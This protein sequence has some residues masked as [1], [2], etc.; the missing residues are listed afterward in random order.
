M[1]DVLVVGS[2]VVDRFHEVDGEVS[3][4]RGGNG[5]ITA[6]WFDNLGYD[7]DL[8]SV[9][10]DDVSIP[11]SIDTSASV[12][13]DERNSVCD[14]FLNELDEPEGWEF[15]PSRSDLSPGIPNESYELSV[16]TGG[17]PGY[18]DLLPYISS[19]LNVFDPDGAIELYKDNTRFERAISQTEIL[20]T[21]S[22]EAERIEKMLGIEIQDLCETFGIEEIIVTDSDRVTIYRPENQK[23]YDVP[24]L[25]EIKDTTGAGCGFLAGYLDQTIK[26]SSESQAVNQGIEYAQKIIQEIGGYPNHQD[27]KAS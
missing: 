13:H 17:H 1:G 23:S 24:E 15:Y 2:T 22:E 3:E 18:G 4:A 21:N 7:V 5:L 26:D 25:D 10:G 11:E 27:S 20:R 6:K 12:I 9:M 8:A 14:I 19:E 16:V